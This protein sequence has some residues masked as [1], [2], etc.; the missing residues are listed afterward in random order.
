MDATAA[1]AGRPVVPVWQTA[2]AAYRLGL[3]AVF[4]DFAVFRYFLYAGGLALLVA[5]GHFYLVGVNLKAATAPAADDTMPL[6]QLGAGMLLDAFLAFALTPFGVALHRKILFRESPRGVYFGG[7]MAPPR[8]RFFLATLFILAIYQVFALAL[9]PVLYLLYGVNAL[10]TTALASAYRSNHALVTTTALLTYGMIFVMAII[11]ARCSL[12]FPAA[13]MARP[14]PWFREA[15]REARGTAARLFW[16]FVV[17]CIPAIIVFFVAII[18][19]SLAF[20]VPRL[21]AHMTPQQMR[22]EMVLSAPFLVLYAFMFAVAMLLTAVIGAGA[23]RA[24]EIRTNGDTSRVAE[25]FS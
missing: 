15:I 18:G 21:Q 22:G 16:L 10:N 19:A 20:A 7:A 2:K 13:A 1:T 24:Y 23:A 17:I 6:L 11:V 25:I 12:L 3:G 9:I 8:R 5:T 14:G 4:G